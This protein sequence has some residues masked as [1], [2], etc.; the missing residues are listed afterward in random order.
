MAVANRRGGASEICGKKIYLKHFFSNVNTYKYSDWRVG[1]MYGVTSDRSYS[2][3]CMLFPALPYCCFSFVQALVIA[4]VVM[5]PFQV[6]LGFR[7]FAGY[8]VRTP[9]YPPI[10]QF[11]IGL[12]QALPY[13]M[14]VV[15]EPVRGR[16]MAVLELIQGF[17]L[18]PWYFVRTPP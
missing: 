3:V 1:G 18:F 6:V 14:E 12:F 9:P 17:R 7:R 8:F 10:R 2:K 11:R 4:L 5:A 13:G 15:K 16:V